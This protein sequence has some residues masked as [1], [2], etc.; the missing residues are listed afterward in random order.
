VRAAAAR[1]RYGGRV[2]HAR[3][4]PLRSARPLNP[5][6]AARARLRER[7]AGSGPVGRRCVVRGRS[8]AARAAQRATLTAVAR[9][10]TDQIGSE[11][12]LVTL[13]DLR[14]GARLRAARLDGGAPPRV[15]A[16]H[17]AGGLLLVGT[18]GRAVH[19]LDAALQ[20]LRVRPRPP[21]PGSPRGVQPPC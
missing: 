14:R 2:R 4:G 15:L 16:F 7:A 19:F 13:Y 9:R 20:R 21:A 11:D 17:P 5:S 10:G 12:G 1:A 8:V 6:R 3:P 18:R